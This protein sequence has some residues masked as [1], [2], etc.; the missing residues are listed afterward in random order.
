[1]L[2][3]CKCYDQSICYDG[4]IHGI[5]MGTKERD[6]CFCEGNL[7]YC[8]FYND[9]R[10][11]AIDQLMQSSHDTI[12]RRHL[13]KMLLAHERQIPEWIINVIMEEPYVSGTDGSYC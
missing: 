2:T 4:E 10:V 1:M 3:T 13:L 9:I 11:S 8:D 5:C 7:L 12:S 6:R